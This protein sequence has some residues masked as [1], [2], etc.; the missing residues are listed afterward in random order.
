MSDPQIKAH[1]DSLAAFPEVLK[2]QIQGLDDRALRYRSATEAWSVVEIAGHVMEV[3]A[4]WA[5]RIRHMLAA[6][7]PTLAPYDPAEA[8]RQQKF[9]DKQPGGILITFAERRAEHVEFLRGLR[10]AQLARTGVHPTRGP[11]SVADSIAILDAHDRLHSE[12]IAANLAA[13]RA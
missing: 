11:I 2:R 13:Y 1:L 6:E 7:H 12:Q 3:E 4:L 10:P 5:G 8:V 9:Q